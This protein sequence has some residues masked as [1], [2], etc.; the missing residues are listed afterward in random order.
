MCL[1]D[2]FVVFT[3]AKAHGTNKAL[4]KVVDTSVLRYP[5]KTEKNRK[6]NEKTKKVAGIQ[7]GGNI[8]PKCSKVCITAAL[9]FWVV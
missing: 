9:N 7:M 3:K 8:I 6:L 2:S 1:G 4:T 5:A